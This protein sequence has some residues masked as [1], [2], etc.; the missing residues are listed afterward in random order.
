MEA[1]QNSYSWLETSWETMNGTAVINVNRPTAGSMLQLAS[2]Q[3]LMGAPGTSQ[4]DD[5]AHSMLEIGYANDGFGFWGGFGLQSEEDQK[6]NYYIEGA[7]GKQLGN[8]M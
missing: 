6:S 8:G 5:P 7:F 3:R 1:F 4:L 2:Y